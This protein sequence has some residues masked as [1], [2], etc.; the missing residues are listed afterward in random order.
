MADNTE[1]LP[2]ILATQYHTQLTSMSEAAFN[3][4]KQHALTSARIH[5]G[6]VYEAR[7]SSPELH[8]LHS[9]VSFNIL[10]EKTTSITH[11]LAQ[12][13]I[14]LSLLDDDFKSMSLRTAQIT[15]DI[16]RLST[17]TQQPIEVRTLHKE[18][19]IS[20]LT[21]GYLV[22]HPDTTLQDMIDTPPRLRNREDRG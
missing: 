3:L 18:Q 6:H 5:P 14:L 2:N 13:G 16:W 19:L 8:F 15:S 7:S 20:R 9:A 17:P 11:G 10:V 1:Y 12:F 4:G 22:E 21:T